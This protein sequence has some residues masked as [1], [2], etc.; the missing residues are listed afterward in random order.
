MATTI[1]RIGGGAWLLGPIAICFSS[2]LLVIHA[3]ARPITMAGVVLFAAGVI[4]AY[5]LDHWTDYPARH[6]FLL[7]GVV[8]VAMLAGLGATFWLPG[9]K[10]VLA[11]MLGIMSVA[12]RRWKKWPLAKTLLV[13][14]AW[15]IA[16]VAF[17]IKWHAHELLSAPLNIALFTT[18]AAN[19]L[20]CDL[21]DGIADSRAGVGSA[22]VLWGQPVATALAAGLA[23]TGMLAALAA[24]RQGLAGAGLALGL[25]AAFPR[26]VSRPVLGPALV[27]AALTLPA[28]F[29]LAGLT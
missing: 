29:I 17:P 6:S 2:V 26:W 18:F 23:L 24:H 4:A 16:S 13:A 22:V 5:T 3:T 1:K 19:A 10:I 21:K 7:P 11:L 28:V 8:G 9:W 14:G 12:Y 25:L 27:D 20:L 15:T